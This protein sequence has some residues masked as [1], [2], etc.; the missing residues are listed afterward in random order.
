MTSIAD[1]IIAALNSDAAFD[2]GLSH[3]DAALVGSN[4]VTFTYPAPV[5]SG[6]CVG[7]LTIA[8]DGSIFDDTMDNVHPNVD[9]FLADLRS[10]M[11]V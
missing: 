7:T 1:Q 6:A 2:N 8:A 4:V 10:M 5:V 9:S 11:E 3:K